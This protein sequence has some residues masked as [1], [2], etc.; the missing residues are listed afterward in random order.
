LSNI[1]KLFKCCQCA[2]ISQETIDNVKLKASE[3]LE[4]IAR[5]EKVQF[6]EMDS[7]QASTIIGNDE[8]DFIFIDDDH[9][10]EDFCNYYPKVKSGG[11]FHGHDYSLESVKAILA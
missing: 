10:Y 7:T 2:F 6:L 9:S 3:N 4:S 11:I 8:L 1:G 5:S